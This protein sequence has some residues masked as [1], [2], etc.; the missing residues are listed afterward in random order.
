MLTTFDLNALRTIVVAV[1]LGSFARAAQHLGR[2][3]SAVS[4]QLKKLEDQTGV[5]LFVRSGK[6]LVATEAGETLLAYAEKMIHLNDEAASSLDSTSQSATVRL[7]MPQDFAKT[8]LPDIL[9]AFKQEHP[10][11]LVEAHIGRNYALAEEVKM[12]KLDSALIFTPET[13]HQENRVAEMD[14]IWAG[15]N[16]A[17]IIQANNPLPFV[18]FNFP[19]EFRKHGIQA[20]ENAGRHWRDALMTPS[21]EGIWAA[22]HAGIGITV[23]TRYQ[24]PAEFLILSTD[25]DLPNLPKMYVNHLEHSALTPAAT[26]LSQITKDIATT[27]L[28]KI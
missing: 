9:K 11:V 5:P 21:L 26:C 1:K 23:R 10:N 3:Q 14:M 13:D 27:H 22:L 25:S 16:A 20:L 12:G 24:T 17:E 7:G 6:K 8:L 28:T 4:M 19:C 18:S 15:L 2:S